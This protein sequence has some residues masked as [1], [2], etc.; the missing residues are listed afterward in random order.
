MVKV[1]LCRFRQSTGPSCYVFCGRD[2]LNR[3]LQTFIESRFSETVIW[4]IHRLGGSSFFPECSKFN[5][6]F[7][8]AEKNSEKVFCL[9]DNSI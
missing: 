8:N 6:D 4:E 1:V 7:K 5:V 3:I 2:L 9:G